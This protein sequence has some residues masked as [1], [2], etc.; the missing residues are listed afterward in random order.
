MALG[1]MSL[2]SLNEAHRKIFTAINLIC[3]MMRFLPEEFFQINFSREDNAGIVPFEVLFPHFGN[4]F[5]IGSPF[6]FKTN[7]HLVSKLA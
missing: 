6:D 1:E 7:M 2:L 3:L 5:E 4:N